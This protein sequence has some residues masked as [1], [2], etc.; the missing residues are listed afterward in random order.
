MENEDYKI[1][2]RKF[3]DI[4]KYFSEPYKKCR[5]N[6]PLDKTVY[7]G[8]ESRTLSNI[9]NLPNLETLDGEIVMGS[10][11]GHQHTQKEKGDKR[12]FQEIYD[13]LWYG[14]MFVRNKEAEAVLYLLSPN[15]KIIVGTDENM[16][17]LNFDAIALTTHD[18]ANHD[19]NSANKELEKRIG[20]CLLI[21]HKDNAFYFYINS[22]YYEEGILNGKNLGPV[23]IKNVPYGRELYKAML[24]RKNEFAERGIEIVSGGNI[25][26]GLAKEFQKPLQ[27]LIQEKNKALFNTL[28]IKR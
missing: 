3:Q 1:N 2:K 23:T 20:T 26:K 4:E 18:F 28:Q 16:T 22:K 14:G 21:K 10:T 19:I 7:V 27:V 8:Y 9:T 5:F 13:F 11:M 6:C 12:K 24:S 17:I 25:P 15:E